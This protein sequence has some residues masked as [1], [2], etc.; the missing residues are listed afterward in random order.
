MLLLA[1]MTQTNQ[2]HLNQVEAIQTNTASA[3]VQQIS[4]TNLMQGKNMSPF[5]SNDTVADNG[6]VIEQNTTF[7]N[8]LSQINGTIDG[9]EVSMIELGEVQSMTTMLDDEDE[10]TLDPQ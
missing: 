7:S 9:E 4:V 3:S 10:D 8:T 5:R 2:E 1:L 6:S